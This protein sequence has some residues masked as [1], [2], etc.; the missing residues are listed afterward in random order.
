MLNRRLFLLTATGLTL[1]SFLTGCSQKVD[2]K[3]LLLQGS[4]PVQLITAFRKEINQSQGFVFKPK[5]K[6]IDL[7]TLLQSWQKENQISQPNSQVNLNLFGK[8]EEEIAQLVTLSNYW[9]NQAIKEQLIEPFAVENIPNW[10]QLPPSFIKLVTRN[11][12]GNLDQLG[13]IWGIPYR[14]GCTMIVYRKE[15]FKKLGWNPT[16]WSDLWR[17][18]IKD[19]LSLL[20]EPR[21]II[22]LTLKKLGYSYNTT[23]LD[24]IPQLK[25]ELINLHQQVKFY[26]STN[27]LQPLI[28]GDT[29]LAVGWS[30]DILSILKR[31]PNLDAV[32]PVSGTSLWA[33]LWGQP[34][35]N[36]PNLELL[37]QWLNFSFQPTSANQ[38]ALFTN[39]S[40]PLLFTMNE[41]QISPD[42][43][44]NSLIYPPQN[45]LEKS[46]FITPLSEDITAKYQQIWQEIVS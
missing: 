6:L 12:Q 41:S 15:E 4:L 36:N 29:W 1:S 44:K 11:D 16:D 39:A 8:K 22:G 3:I 38:I 24:N 17:E 5:S 13:K 34:K 31:Y 23:N 20:N 9:L 27:Y 18:E 21:E 26:D 37:N 45:F 2:F 25:P 43:L 28:L 35:G 40:S 33:D 10:N 7:F 42:I 30:S 19:H 14:W 32:I 46:E